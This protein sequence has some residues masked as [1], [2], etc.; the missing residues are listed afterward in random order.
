M[1]SGILGNNFWWVK[2]APTEDKKGS[3][4]YYKIEMDLVE[5]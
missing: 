5:A 4:W 3:T 1:Q 2:A